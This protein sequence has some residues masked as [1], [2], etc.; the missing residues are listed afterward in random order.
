MALVGLPRSPAFRRHQRPVARRYVY[1][2]KKPPRAGTSNV[3]VRSCVGRR[4][5]PAI[6][7]LSLKSEI[8]SRQFTELRIQ[9]LAAMDDG[10]LGRLQV[11]CYGNEQGLMKRQIATLTL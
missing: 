9:V 10:S 6:A 3:S 5:L 1:R 7:P 11:S 8:G 2:T 4:T